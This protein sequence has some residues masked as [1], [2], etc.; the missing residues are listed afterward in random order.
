MAS[1][2]LQLNSEDCSEIGLLILEYVAK[3]Q[4]T[5]TEMAERVGISRAALR[6]VC[7]KR[8]NPGKRTIPRLSEV[9]E[10]PEQELC[11]MVCENKLKLMYE[12]A[13]VVELT[14]STLDSFVQTLHRRLGDVPEEKK[15]AH[16]ELYEHAL[17][18]VTSLPCKT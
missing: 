18:A 5:F 3:Y 17:K 15:P 7:L 12:E 8:G 16:Y 13:E 1:P 4:L 2:H 14:L 6:I 10:K 11:R 9:L